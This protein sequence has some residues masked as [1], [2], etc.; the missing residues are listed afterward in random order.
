MRRGVAMVAA[1][2]ASWGTWSLFLRPTHLPSN[3]TSPILFVV[4]AIV[5]WPLSWREPRGAWDRDTLLLLAGNTVC[6]ALNVLTFFAALRYTTVAIAVLTH[7]FAPILIALAA[8][9]IDG[10]QTRGAR[11]AA[12]VALAGLAI[13]LEPWHAPAAGAL[14]GAALGLASAGCYAGNVFVVRRLATRIGN[15]RAV[16]YHSA[17]AAVLL[18]PLAIPDVAGVTAPGLAL[19][20]AG[21]ATIGAVS[22]ILFVAGLRRIGAARAAVLTYAEPLVAVCVGA[23]VWHEPVSAL[24]S[25]GGALVLAAGVHVARQAA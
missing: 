23:L 24:A 9:R 16:A 8:P 17:L 12:L 11:A 18:A 21:A 13:V 1:A 14:A 19:L 22:G 4:M 25:V 20:T 2:A 6:D 3:V 5:A 10:V 15:A 7:Y